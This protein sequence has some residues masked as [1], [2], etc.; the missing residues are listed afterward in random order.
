MASKAQSSLQQLISENFDE[1][2]AQFFSAASDELERILEFFDN[3]EKEMKDRF[4]VL[5]R[6]LKEVSCLSS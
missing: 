6:Q 3:R 2:E 4:T 1:S 5:A